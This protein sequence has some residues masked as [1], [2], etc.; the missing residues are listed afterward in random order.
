MQ[1]IKLQ[2]EDNTYRNIVQKGINIQEKFK[3][4]ITDLAQDS[5][6]SVSSKEAEHRVTKAVEN[7]QNGTM[8]T[9][10]HDEAWTQIDNHI[11]SKI[12]H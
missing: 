9:I 12:E 1:T 4:F 7:Y 11:E 6:P 8:K 2:L 3:E 5:Y 10:A